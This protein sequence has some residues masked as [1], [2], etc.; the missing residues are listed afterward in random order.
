MPKS[1]TSQQD[2]LKIAVFSILLAMLA[3]SFGDAMIKLLSAKFQLWQ[4]YIVRSSLAVPILI[5]IIKIRE[6]T[7]SL[8]PVSLR[9][10]AIRS[11]LLATMWVAYYTALP[12]I[13]LSVAA[14]IYYTSPLFITLFS[15]L[16][17]G[18]KVGV[19]SWL[20]VTLGF[21]GVLVIVRPNNEEFNPFVLL[22][23]LAAILYS[24]AMILTRAKCVS[25]NPKILSLSLNVTFILVGI[26]ASL[27]IAI[28]NPTENEVAIN[29]FLFGE[30]ASLDVK[31]WLAMALLAV[32]IILGSFFTAIAYQ[33]GPSSI[34]AAFDY[35]YLAFSV[36]WGW[37]IFSDALDTPT[38]IGMAM[39][40][41]AGLM[42]IKK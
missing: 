22:P 32:V 24:L 15:A 36:L 23:L 28:W 18:D 31:G 41:G 7:L 10:T 6:P 27:S 14:A 1:Y 30:W 34:V 29:A 26:I 12:H 38:V 40:A 25:E 5:A 2:N 13:Q 19:K 37:L 42:A 20:A 8:V 33:S 4:I 39:I 3:L 16:F 35:S 21:V 11:L 17:T 9:W